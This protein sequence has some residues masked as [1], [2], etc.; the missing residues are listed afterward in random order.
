MKKINPY[1]FQN[2][3][4]TI[5]LVGQ[6]IISH[7]KTNIPPT[8]QTTNIGTIYIGCHSKLPL[9]STFNSDN[10]YKVY[11][12][13]HIIDL[14]DSAAGIPQFLETEKHFFNSIEEYLYKLSGR[15]ICIACAHNE[16]RIYLDASG[17]LSL[18]YSPSQKVCASTIMSIPYSSDTTDNIKLI[19]DMDIINKDTTFA[20]GLTPRKAIYRLLPNHYL[21]L[22]T[23]KAIRH[24][25]KK[26]ISS[27]NNP[28]AD[29]LKIAKLL[30]KTIKIACQ[31][32]FQI[33]M[34][35]TAGFDS[36][37]LLACAKKYVKSIHF[38]TWELPDNIALNDVAIAKTLAR[39]FKLNYKLYPFKEAN[40]TD[41][42]LWRYRT[43]LS[44]GEMRGLSLT[45]T[46][47][48]MDEN[49]LYFPGLASEVG[50]G[51]YWQKNDNL[52]IQLTPE[53]LVK[54]MD[55]PLN[56]EVILAAKIWLQNLPTDNAFE[57]LDLLYLEQRLGCWASVT[58][59]ADAAGPA[60][61][62]P[63]SNREIFSLMLSL[64]AHFKKNDT[65]PLK[66]INNYWPELY[67][68]PVNFVYYN[69]RGEITSNHYTQLNFYK[70]I[71][72]KM[73]IRYVKYMKKIS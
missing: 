67:K 54:R 68:Y 2:T 49:Q 43:G 22:N 44:V 30:E 31:E 12:L 11:F 60:R 64:P 69:S 50:R 73:I 38:F 25:P 36:R 57:I 45:T 40:A 55:L 8:W 61:I 52:S 35:L 33:M 20:F 41:K 4:S 24:W 63:F 10:T 62:L 5:D 26:K 34:S 27:S 56:K 14:N 47:N 37:V 7:D 39:K 66:I 48:A 46:V 51:F 17:S 15:Y 71:L 32:K 19:N 18:V 70:R 21:N 16:T 6:F 29:V 53:E 13:G 23:W 65:I 59:Y 72:K 3:F 28:D 58:A 9:I 1:D 42:E